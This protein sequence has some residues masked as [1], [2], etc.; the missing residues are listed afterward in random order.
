MPVINRESGPPPPPPPRAAYVLCRALQTS[1]EERPGIAF[2]HVSTFQGYVY[3]S[4][5]P[6]LPS[7]LYFL[8]TSDPCFQPRSRA[9]F[10]GADSPRIHAAG[11]PRAPA[12]VDFPFPL[13][14][15]EDVDAANKSP[16]STFKRCLS[17]YALCLPRLKYPYPR[18]SPFF[19]LPLLSREEGRRGAVLM[20]LLAWDLELFFFFLL[21]RFDDLVISIDFDQGLG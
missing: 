11:F 12:K 15:D 17:S 20:P 14:D 13:P 19:L 3:S 18:C 21:L 1:V 5:I 7:F 4:C 10:A 8:L 16:S 2:K 6:R 9:I